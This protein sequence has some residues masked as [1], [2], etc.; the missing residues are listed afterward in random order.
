MP[1]S[2]VMK[3]SQLEGIKLYGSFGGTRLLSWASES[4][5]G[6]WLVKREEGR[7][8]WGLDHFIPYTVDPCCYGFLRLSPRG[9]GAVKM[10]C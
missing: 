5:K 6:G 7:T 9:H 10:I 3:K 4:F 2:N 8:S 1:H